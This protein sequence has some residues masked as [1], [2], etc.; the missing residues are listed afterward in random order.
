MT[1]RSLA[2]WLCFLVLLPL[3]SASAARRR[4]VSP[5]VPPT[6]LTANPDAYAAGQGKALS[7][8]A[9]K[10]VLVNDRDPRGKALIALLVS[11]PKHGTLTFNADGSFTYTNDGTGAASDSFTYQASNGTASSNIAAVTITIGAPDAIL[12]ASDFYSL[13]HGGNITVG[14]PGVLANDS[15]PTARC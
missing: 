4:A 2:P 3:S 10:G 11:N 8:A 7:V 12:A 1:I 6:Q 9:G 5:S 14:A 15:I 13:P